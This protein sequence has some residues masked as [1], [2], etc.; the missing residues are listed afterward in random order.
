MTSTNPLLDLALLHTRH[1]S[2]T[3]DWHQDHQLQELPLPWVHIQQ[4]HHHNFLLWHHEDIARRDDLPDSAIRQAKR[5]I[6][7]NNQ[8]RNN[9]MEHLDEWMLMTLT[10]LGPCLSTQPM[11][12]E[13]PGMIVDRLSILSLKAY[14]MAEQAARATATNEHRTICNSKYQLICNQI[15]DLLACLDLL[16][17]ELAAGRK[18]FKVYRQFKMYNDPQLNPQLYNS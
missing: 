14:H 17:N 9:A 18:G 2:W 7:S 6:D 16:L 10:E 11:H 13:T 5:D 12:S 3:C 1:H 4:N 8:L 15:L